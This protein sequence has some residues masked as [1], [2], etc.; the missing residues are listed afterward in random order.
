MEQGGPITQSLFGSIIASKN[1]S[2]PFLVMELRTSTTGWAVRAITG[3]LPRLLTALYQPAPRL[4]SN[5]I[6]MGVRGRVVIRACADTG[7][8]EVRRNR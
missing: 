6:I 3:I 8:S 1:G 7:S 5:L 4:C 2:W